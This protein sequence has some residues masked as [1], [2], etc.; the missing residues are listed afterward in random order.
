MEVESV[1]TNIECDKAKPGEAVYRLKDSANLFLVVYP[2]GRRSWEYRYQ[3]EGKSQALILGEYGERKPALGPKAART[4]RDEVSADRARG[5]DPI[6]AKKLAGEQQHQALVTARAEREYRR[7][8]KERVRLESERGAITF[9]V[10]AARWLAVNRAHWSKAHAAQ[11]EQSLTDHVYPK[12]GSKHPEKIEPAHVLDLIDGMLTDGKVE[13]ARRVRQRM[14]AVFEHAGLY[15][16]V[17]VN[18][19]ALAKRELSKRFKVATKANPEEHFACVSRKEAPQLLRAMREYVGTPVTR[20]LLWF[21]ALTACRTG[22]ARGATW[23][24][25]DFEEATW[26]IP[27]SR[28]KAGREHVVYLDSAVVDLLEALRSHTR[29]LSW[30][31]PHPTRKDKPAS[32]N[33]VLYALAAI[34]FKGKHSGHGFRRL[35]STIANESGLHRPDVIE[36]ALAHKEGNEIRAAYNAATYE[37]ER[38]RLAS[39]YAD[40]LARLEAGVAA[41][42]VPIKQRA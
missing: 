26:T 18:P 13:T 42:I 23:E 25:F 33:A 1:L 3:R 19:V 39:W 37:E 22:E 21:V 11:N 7:K 31:F 41:K 35:F 40:E 6:A 17:K 24:E 12:I 14:D 9:K 30:V 34:G 27:A 38:R 20:S 36:A 16:G 29:G 2:S 15:Y 10:V 32:E 8:E 4:R 5:L 28:M